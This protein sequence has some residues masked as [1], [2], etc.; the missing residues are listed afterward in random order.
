MDHTEVNSMANS[1]QNIIKE[2]HL[3]QNRLFSSK[4]CEDPVKCDARQVLILDPLL[5]NMLINDIDFYFRMR[6]LTPPCIHK[7]L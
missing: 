1:I 2:F 4:I 7:K 5:L 3:F 6:S